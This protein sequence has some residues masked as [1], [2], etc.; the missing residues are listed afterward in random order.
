MKMNRWAKVPF[1]EVLKKG[2]DGIGGGTIDMSFLEGCR[3]I[4]AGYLNQKRLKDLD[5]TEGGFAID[6]LRGN[7]VCRVVFGSSDYG[8]W[9]EWK[10][11]IGKFNP[12]DLLSP[13]DLLRERIRAAWNGT[14]GQKI[15]IEDQPLKR[16]YSFVGKKSKEVLFLDCSDLK[17]MGPKVYRHF[18][19][20]RR[21]A[22]RILYYI[23]LWANNLQ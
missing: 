1:L 22:Q 6:Y 21:D 18:S 5:R 15:H 7:K 4:K 16:G 14:L 9:I 2:S 8:L 13:E 11:E 19:S 20:T 23:G 17:R 12:R 10:G 3:I